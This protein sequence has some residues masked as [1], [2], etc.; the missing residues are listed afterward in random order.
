[1]RVKNILVFFVFVM[2][3]FV[4]VYFVG[5]TSA[6]PKND[7]SF[8]LEFSQ[9]ILFKAPSEPIQFFKNLYW[10]R[11]FRPNIHTSIGAVVVALVP[12]G[13]VNWIQGILTFLQYIF[14]FAGCLLIF[15]QTRSNFELAA[16]LLLAVSFPWIFGNMTIYSSEGMGL[17]ALTWSFY[18]LQK[19]NFAEFS[20][21]SN[22]RWISG[23][24]I[25]AGLMILA[26]PVEGCL[27][28]GSFILMS[29][30]AFQEKVLRGWKTFLLVLLLLSGP[31]EFCIQTVALKQRHESISLTH[32]ALSFLT[33]F[34]GILFLKKRSLQN[35]TRLI[36]PCSFMVYAWYGPFSYE[37][38]WWAFASSLGERAQLTGGRGDEV[39]FVFIANAVVAYF[40]IAFASFMTLIALVF[41]KWDK[42]RFLFT[43]ALSFP[44][45]AGA[46]TYN[47]DLR[48]Y[49]FSGIGIFFVIFSSVRREGYKL[50]VAAV[51]VFALLFSYHSLSVFGKWEQLSFLSQPYLGI[52][53][54]TFEREEDK[55]LQIVSA[56]K[57]SIDL[58]PEN[59][60][61][62]LLMVSKNPA[63]Q[64]FDPW[65]TTY[66]LRKEGYKTQ[67]VMPSPHYQKNVA[68]RFE[69]LVKPECCYVGVYPTE[70]IPAPVGHYLN[71]VGELFLKKDADQKLDDLG[72]SYLKSLHWNF[73]NMDAEL[74]IFQSNA[75]ICRK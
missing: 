6:L 45:L 69:Y 44:L 21:A 62:L 14:Y 48:Y 50:K 47:G 41:T 34:P 5:F 23:L 59:Q 56:V 4:Y 27:I 43:V 38:F 7:E 12:G 28:F 3:L 30:F 70:Y 52:W 37:T 25:F 51:S 13:D 58:T 67:F 55:L 11:T 46:F 66:L 64:L 9:R 31:I 54:K 17:V 18:C 63:M 73:Y 33:F 16:L 42:P 1:M 68:D 49:I 29:I 40:G 15:R 26:K 22:S 20:I 71:D 74:R 60:F 61:C 24:S 75:G 8:N 53:P 2:G 72:Y 57:S 32:F 19:I 65:I 36:V 10:D 35:F 39:W